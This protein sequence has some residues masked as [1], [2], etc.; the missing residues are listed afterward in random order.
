MAFISITTPFQDR[1]LDAKELVGII[2]PCCQHRPSMHNEVV[3]MIQ[4]IHHEMESNYQIPK[5]RHLVQF[6]PA[7]PPTGFSALVKDYKHVS[8][9]MTLADRPNNRIKLAALGKELAKDMQ[10][11]HEAQR[12]KALK[13]QEQNEYDVQ[14]LSFVVDQVANRP[15]VYNQVVVQLQQLHHQLLYQE[16]RRRPCFGANRV[17]PAVLTWKKEVR[18]TSQERWKDV[19]KLDEL[20]DV[21][22][23]PS[24]IRRVLQDLQIKCRNEAKL[25]FKNETT[26]SDAPPA[27]ISITS[28][29]SW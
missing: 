25:L 7:L 28:S 18:P 15:H 11:Y 24:S 19:A 12:V 20:L 4:Q 3:K 9:L 21:I 6:V 10:Q 27:L 2:L 1:A 5:H 8:H 17:A 22:P 23:E 26:A 13:R 14:L 16:R 29:T